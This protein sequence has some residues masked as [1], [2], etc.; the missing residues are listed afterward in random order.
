MN[1]AGCCGTASERHTGVGDIEGSLVA[2]ESVEL[3]SKVGMTVGRSQSSNKSKERNKGGE[4]VSLSELQRLV[5]EHSSRITELEGE[6]RRS[7]PGGADMTSPANASG[8]LNAGD[9]PSGERHGSQMASSY[10][11]AESEV[12]K[13]ASLQRFIDKHYD[14]TRRRGALCSGALFGLLGLPFG[15]VGMAAGGMIGAL[16]G[17]MIGYCVDK[18]RQNKQFHDSEA[19][20]RR[21][22]SISRWAMARVHDPEEVRRQLAFVILEFKPVADVS[23]KSP[24]ARKLLKLLDKWVSNKVV[25]KELW[26]FMDEFLQQWRTRTRKDIIKTIHMFQTLEAMYQHSTRNLSEYETQFLGRVERLLR[27]ESVKVAMAQAAIATD[28]DSRIMQSIEAMDLQARS[29]ATRGNTSPRTPGGSRSRGDSFNVVIQEEESEDGNDDEPDR[30]HADESKSE[31]TSGSPSRAGS[32]GQQ[33][34][35]F[36]SWNDYMEFDLTIK[37]KIPITRC[38]F[39]FLLQK[40]AESEIGWDV[41]FER[42]EIRV[43]K[44]TAGA[45]VVFLRGWATLPDID[46][47]V[48][49]QLFYDVNLRLKWDSVFQEM[50]LGEQVKGSDLLYSLI[51]VPLVTPRDFLQ[52]RRVMVQDDGTILIVMRSAEHDDFPEYRGNIRAESFISGYVFRQS[53]DERGKPVLN[54]FLMTCTDIK[55]LVPKWVINTTAPR[56][57]YEWVE[58]LRKFA[59]TYQESNPGLGEELSG[60]LDRFKGGFRDE[61]GIALEIPYN[62]DREHLA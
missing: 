50:R 44:T 36:K 21:L 6:L 19:T 38:E 31:G 3:G 51:R 56:K 28:Q 26:R 9:V 15:P 55:G 62:S 29:S 17:G 12:G 45:G 4:E 49:F 60:L 16:S 57:P 32:T 53:Y 40:E 43:C 39:D 14:K 8:S 34:A 10:G 46:M 18:H 27:H 24:N 1:L 42:K 48:A 61:E 13:P 35:F 52:Y 30:E 5:Q 7:K 23:D 22:D 59:L 37:H 47:R 41:C 58:A 11:R 20:K 33:P 2:Y 25:T 54:L